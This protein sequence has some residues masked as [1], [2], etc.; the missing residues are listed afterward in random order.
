MCHGRKLDC[1]SRLGDA[2]NQS[3]FIGVCNDLYN[4]LFRIPNAGWMTINHIPFFDHGTYEDK[5]IRYCT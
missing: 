2:N 1:I 4:I 5:H 3:M